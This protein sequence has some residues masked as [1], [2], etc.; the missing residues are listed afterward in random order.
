MARRMSISVQPGGARPGKPGWMQDLYE[1]HLASRSEQPRPALLGQ[2][3][4][5]LLTGR[6]YAGARECFR[7]ARLPLR[8][9]RLPAGMRRHLRLN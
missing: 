5:Q 4:G 8:I 3:Y 2:T 9:P 7:A 1:A 6:T